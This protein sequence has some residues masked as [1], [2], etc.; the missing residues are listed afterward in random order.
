MERTQK[1]R[2]MKEEEQ[3]NEKKKKWEIAQ[4]QQQLQESIELYKIVNE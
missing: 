4:Q 3:K 1:S 2:E